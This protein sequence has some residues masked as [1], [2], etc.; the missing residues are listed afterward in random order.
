MLIRNEV[1]PGPPVGLCLWVTRG[2]T[3]GPAG[4]T[5][6]PAGPTVDCRTCRSDCRFHLRVTRSPTVIQFKNKTDAARL[7]AFLFLDITS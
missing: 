2:P 5:V 6:R 7:K 4:P 1:S 3:V